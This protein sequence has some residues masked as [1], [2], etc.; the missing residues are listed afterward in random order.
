MG[1]VLG[2]QAPNAASLVHW[3]TRPRTDH[4]GGGL[5][6]DRYRVAVTVDEGAD[7]EKAFATARDRLLRYR[8]FPDTVLRPFVDSADGL[9]ARDVVVVFRARLPLLPVAIEAAVRVVETWDL[10]GP[11]GE[12][13]SGLEVATLAGHPERG[14]ERFEI[15]LEPGTRRLG[16]TIEAW[17]RPGSW[18]VRL[19][20]PVTR[21]VQVRAARAALGQFASLAGKPGEPG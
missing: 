10:D 3:R 7:L 5:Q 12:R 19:G 16:F 6:H 21:W 9:V 20:G 14:H 8:I 11:S 4:D 17:S 15:E 1:I 2:R 13:R 18:L